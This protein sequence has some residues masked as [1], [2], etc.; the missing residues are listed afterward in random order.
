MIVLSNNVLKSVT[1]FAVKFN[2]EVFS[3]VVI[4]ALLEIV[5][6]IS[7]SAVYTVSWRNKRQIFKQSS[8]TADI[9]RVSYDGFKVIF[10]SSVV[11]S[12]ILGYFVVIFVF[13]NTSYS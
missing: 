12:T 8:T 7:F 3:R 4:C 5:I 13:K 6:D 11:G 9:A 2:D 10:C 1:R